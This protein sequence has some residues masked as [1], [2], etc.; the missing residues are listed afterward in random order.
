METD[1]WQASFS[2]P[3][4]VQGLIELYGGDAAFLEKLEK[5]FTAPSSVL[6]ARPDITGM[7][8]QDAQGNEPSNHHPYLFSFAGAPWKTQYWSR[9]VAGLYNSTPAG[10]PGNDDCGQISSW[11]VF[12]ALGFYPVNAATGVYVLGSPIVD[13]AVLRNPLTGSKFS[14]VAENNSAQNVFIQRAELNG[15]ELHRSWLTHEQ[16]TAEGELHLRMA[17]APDKDWATAPADRPPS[18]L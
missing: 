17:P 1:A 14:I 10:V 11:F 3:H 9:K 2:V 7:V 15:Q 12:A 16:I 6:D 13:R 5:L 8:G 18:G 4:D